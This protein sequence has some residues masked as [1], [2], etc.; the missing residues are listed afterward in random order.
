MPALRLSLALALAALLA[1]SRAPSAAPPVDAATLGRLTALGGSHLI[2]GLVDPRHWEALRAQVEAAVPAAAPALAPLKTPRDA[3]L[4]LGLQPAE[5]DAWRLDAPI[6][7]G[8]FSGSRVVTPGA[9]GAYLPLQ[10][11]PGFRHEAVIPSSAPAVLAGGLQ[12]VAAG[13]GLERLGGHVQVQAEADAVRVALTFGR[14]A[15]PAALTPPVVTA[16]LRALADGR[17]AVGAVFRPALLPDVMSRRGLGQVHEALAVVPPDLKTQLMAAGIAE[18]LGGAGVM[19]A[20]SPDVEDVGLLLGVEGGALTAWGFAT[21][22]PAGAARVARGR[23]TAGRLVEPRPGVAAWA[24][25]AFDLPAALADAPDLP[26]G[27]SHAMAEAVM[28]CGLG[29]SLFLPLRMP[30]TTLKAV[31]D[32]APMPVPRGS[33][34]RAAQWAVV[35]DGRRPGFAVAADVG[36]DFDAAALRLPGVQR[37]ER[38]ERATL[39][40]GVDLDPRAAFDPDREA[41]ADRTLEVDVAAA[42][43]LAGVPVP[44]GLRLQG[45]ARVDGAVVGLRVRAAAGDAP[46]FTLPSAGDPPAAGAPASPGVACL[47][48]A[49]R[50]LALE[51][52][53]ISREEAAAPRTEIE[54]ALACA[55][56]DPQTAAAARGL[57]AQR[58]VFAT[59]KAAPESA[60][61][62]SAAPESAAPES[63]AP[64]SAAGNVPRGRPFLK[65]PMTNIQAAFRQQV[66][67][68]RACY[69]RALL[70][71]PDL[72]A[73]LRLALTIGTAG[74][75]QAATVTG[76]G[77]DP[78]RTCIEAA[79]RA[80][81]FPPGDAPTQVQFPLVFQAPR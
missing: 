64:E 5:A 39:L 81:R 23:A 43:L 62:E 65:I 48:R 55:L 34:P 3:A 69:E 38:G 79:A 60:A 8:A 17:A 37:V 4:A 71:Q 41:P 10:P 22:T 80:I 77:A 24:G 46:P 49:N 12:R 68:L 51:F 53:A 63:A 27:D 21:L 28:S 70:T 35:M 6:I 56:A 40:W 66:P 76:Q 44:A 18:V 74:D 42:A 67:R 33:L 19:T 73:R 47:E 50:G 31:L 61:P 14:P 25:L 36:A 57:A 58:A 13:L 30:F 52:K 7:V 26:L 15:P 9:V 2:V 1:C 54:P 32:R 20:E 16:T 72:N 29:C 75:V 45:T 59:L 11:P 78:L